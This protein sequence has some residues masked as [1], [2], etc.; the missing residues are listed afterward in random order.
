[1]ESSVPDIEE[2]FDHIDDMIT[3]H[4]ADF[5]IIRANAAALRKLRLPPLYTSGI[6][7]YRYYHGMENPPDGYPSCK[8]IVSGSPATFEMFEPHLDL[9]IGI[10]AIPRFDD[11]GQY[12]GMIHIVREL[13]L[14]EK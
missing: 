8:C 1:M 11:D 10:K 7:C 14:K 3:I 5:N 9:L 2:I 6:K 13:P 12:I 4:D